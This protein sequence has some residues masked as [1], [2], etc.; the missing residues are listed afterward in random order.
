MHLE[1]NQ[2]FQKRQINIEENS[3]IIK[4]YLVFYFIKTL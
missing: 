3:N 2:A 4:S 1:I